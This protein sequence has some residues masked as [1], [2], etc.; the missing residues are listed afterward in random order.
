MEAVSRG[1]TRQRLI[2]AAEKLF[3]ERGLDAVSLREINLAAG[4]RNTSAAHYH[5]G[6]KE[7]LLSAIFELRHEALSRRR[8]E[9]VEQLEAEGRSTDLRSLIGVL[10][11]PLA[12]Q[13]APGPGQTH[14]LPFL[15][16]LLMH[17]PGSLREVYRQHRAGEARW[18]KLM[19]AALPDMPES[20]L[21]QR[22]ALMGRHVAMSLA[23][24]QRLTD[25][26]RAEVA[27]LDLELHL[28]NMIDAVAGYVSAPASSETLALLS[29]PRGRAASA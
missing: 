18:R 8:E 2:I 7:A 28:S 26:V 4:Q 5:F 22:L 24:Y 21:R 29:R 10:V 12:E 17:S 9:L 23:T 6:S 11:H 3:A 13:V 19:H 25:P 27:E 16:Q 20:L 14:F 15:S 1:E